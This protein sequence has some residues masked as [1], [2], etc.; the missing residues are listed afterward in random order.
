MKRT[1]PH[2]P[3][4]IV[5]DATKINAAL[6]HICHLLDLLTRYLFIALPFDPGADSRRRIQLKPNLPFIRTTKYRDKNLLS[7]S[8]KNQRGFY[9]SYGL[10]AHSVVY[11]A[12]MQGVEEEDLGANLYGLVYAPGVA[13]SHLEIKSLGF[14]LDVND[15]VEQVLEECGLE[16]EGWALVDA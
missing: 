11:L 12:W 16:E 14:S 5:R 13:K 15:V 6:Q 7:L 8:R 4:D 10:L 1:S 3:A 2:S 9:T